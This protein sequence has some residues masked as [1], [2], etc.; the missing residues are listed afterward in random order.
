MKIL[1][2]K[3]T[4]VKSGHSLQK[5][6][7]L[8]VNLTICQLCSTPVPYNCSFAYTSL[9]CEFGVLCDFFHYLAPYMPLNCLLKDQQLCMICH[10]RKYARLCYVNSLGFSK[11]GNSRNWQLLHPTSTGSERFYCIFIKQ[12]V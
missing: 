1:Y 10:A 2:L 3:L 6:G 9:F 12:S 11:L 7:L 4:F 5:P 8:V